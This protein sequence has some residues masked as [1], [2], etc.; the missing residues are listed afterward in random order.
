MKKHIIGGMII[1]ATIITGV[2]FGG[3]ST[4]PPSMEMLQEEVYYISPKN[5]DGIQDSLS[6]DVNVTPDRRMVILGYRM[7]VLTDGG[8]PVRKVEV[9]GEKP[10]FLRKKTGLELPEAVIWD[11]R[12]DENRFVVDGGYRVFFHAWDH[13]N[14]IVTS[15]PIH[16]VVDNTLP[17]AELSIPYRFFSPNGDGAA[18]VVVISPAYPLDGVDGWTFIVRNE[19]KEEVYSLSGTAFQAFTWE[20]RGNVG[21]NSGQKVRDGKYYV[22]FSVLYENGN[23]PV[24]EGGPIT[25]DTAAPYAYV[26]PEYTIFSPDGDGNRDTLT[27]QVMDSS[28]ETK[29]AVELFNTAGGRVSGYSWKGRVQTVMW[30]GRME[31]GTVV[32]DGA[33]TLRLQSVDEAE[34][35][36]VEEIKGIRIDTRATPVNLSISDKAFSPNGDGR[37]DMF[38]VDQ[39]SSTEDVWTGVIINSAGAEIVGR[40]WQGKAGRF[41]WEGK[42]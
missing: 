6:V 22:T 25:V 24:V 35:R 12:N 20:G 14:K 41:V 42:D 28:F 4:I 32:R 11:G 33:Y 10:R 18:D 40:T 2:I 21:E 37:R 30:D 39:Q 9:E 36:F 19:E 16:V 3:C 5:G 13:K 15:D 7:E 38:T 23:N 31:D 26:I 29:W 1:A 17:Q 34:N 27:L 8:A